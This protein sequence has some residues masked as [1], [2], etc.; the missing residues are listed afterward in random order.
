MGF[1][2]THCLHIY[3][4]FKVYF[5]FF[6]G[7][8]SINFYD[9][10]AVYFRKIISNYWPSRIVC[11]SSEAEPGGAETAACSPHTQLVLAMVM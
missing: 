9:V 10:L 8:V 5:S 7:I 6:F 1:F 3:F 11:L 4:N 2:D